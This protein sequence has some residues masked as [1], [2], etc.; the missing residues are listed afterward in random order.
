MIVFS[1]CDIATRRSVE[2]FINTDAAV[3]PYLT[4]YF[5]LIFPIASGEAAG[6]KFSFS[7]YG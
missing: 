5:I 6:S 7:Y 3:S 1:H 4:Q 2:L